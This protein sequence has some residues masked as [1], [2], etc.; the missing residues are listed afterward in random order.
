MFHVA[1]SLGVGPWLASKIVAL[2]NTMG[3]GVLGA[4]IITALLS[5]GSLVA[6]DAAADYIVATVMNYLRQNAWAKAV[7]W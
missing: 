4:S 6:W 3:W 5:G 1:S 2:I 7:A